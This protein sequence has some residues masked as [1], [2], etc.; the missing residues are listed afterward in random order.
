VG[1]IVLDAGSV[2]GKIGKRKGPPKGLHWGTLLTAPV[3]FVVG[4][5]TGEHKRLRQLPP[6]EGVFIDEL[7]AVIA[8]ATS[9]RKLQDD[10]QGGQAGAL[11]GPPV[12][13]VEETR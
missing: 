10:E 3:V 12:G 6:V 7:T 8:T 9:C 11:E 2:G 1:L 4:T 13:L 5:A